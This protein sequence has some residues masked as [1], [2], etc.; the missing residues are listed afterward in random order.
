VIDMREVLFPSTDA[1]A[2]TEFV[3]VVV[4]SIV[5]AW[6]VRRERALVMLTIG[7]SMVVLGWFGV[8]SLR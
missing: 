6:L 2:M 8:R 5:L 1:G 4:A 3:L 7:V